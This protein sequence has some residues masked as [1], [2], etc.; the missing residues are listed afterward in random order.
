MPNGFH[1]SLEEWQRMEAPLL[2]MDEVVDEFAS[3]RNLRVIKNYHN[4]PQRQV[5]WTRNGI[6]RTI[7]ILLANEDKMTFHVAVVAA[8]DKNDDRHLKDYWLT[9]E[10][11]WD[12][13]KN[14]LQQL[15]GRGFA[16]LESWDENDLMP[17]AQF[18]AQQ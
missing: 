9:K 14:N 2:E 17:S 10:A 7:S 15:L 8:K 11:P 12:E 5:R 4:W 6:R 1:G 18:R 13:V 3:R 16:L